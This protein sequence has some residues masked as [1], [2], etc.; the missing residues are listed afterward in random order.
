MRGKLEGNANHYTT[1]ALRIAYIESCTSGDA[2]DHLKPHLQDESPN[3]F[4]TARE[5]LD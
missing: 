5:M 2:A 4:Q 1:K 3:K